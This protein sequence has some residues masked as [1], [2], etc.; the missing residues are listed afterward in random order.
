MLTIWGP[1]R[2]FCDGLDRRDFLRIGAFGATLTL[3]DML[4]GQALGAKTRTSRAKAAI[5]IYL[6]GGPTHMDTYDLKPNAPAEYR[7]EF[8]PICTNVPG[9]EICELMPKQ[10]AMMD[11]FAII[12]SVSGIREEHS[13]AQVMSGWSEG[14]N[15]NVGRPSL[16]AVVSKMRSSANPDI[17]QF[18]SLRGLTP[19]L[20]PGYVG[21]AHRAFVPNGP[22][23]NDLRLPASVNINRLDDRKTLLAGFD[24]LRRDVDASG[25][26]A[27]I[28]AFTSRA[29]DIVTSGNIRE[30]LDLNKE[31][32]RVRDRYGKATQFLTARR[33]VEAGVGCVTL[34]IGG[35]DTHGDNFNTMR[36]QLPEVDRALSALVEDL[37]RLG[38]AEDVTV[39]MWGEFGRTPRINGGAGRDH[40]PSVMSCVLAGGGLKMGQVIGA[41]SARGEY[42]KERPCHVQNIMATIYHSL[43]IDPSVQ[44]TS[45]TGRPIYLLDER[46]PIAELV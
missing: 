18:V 38:M 13:D 35:W 25:S 17:P 8:K 28:D 33:L 11:K 34:A 43:G 46:E 32:P 5:M 30:A 45:G 37:H 22:G 24:K 26:M 1:K 39:V 27:G 31:D 2:R 19:G 9:M 14:E 16:G 20:E 3:A 7:G 21:V 29:F 4:R 15:R 10:A 36:R 12:R 23:L 42:P 41:S 6:P 44:F 40:W